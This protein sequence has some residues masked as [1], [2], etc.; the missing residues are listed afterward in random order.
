MDRPLIGHLSIHGKLNL[1]QSTC[2]PLKGGSERLF[3]VCFYDACRRL[4]ASGRDK[5]E[6]HSPP[7]FFFFY[8]RCTFFSF[9]GMR[10]KLLYGRLLRCCLDASSNAFV[11]HSMVFTISRGFCWKLVWSLFTDLLSL[12]E[13]LEKKSWILIISFEF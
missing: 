7:F 11:E 4:P 8:P 2:F 6:K 13:S 5:K 3:T 10:V 12:K 1:Q 9:F